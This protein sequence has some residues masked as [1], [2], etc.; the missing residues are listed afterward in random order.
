[1]RQWLWIGLLTICACILS[2]LFIAPFGN[3]IY[4]I[5]KELSD[6]P[7]PEREHE[8]FLTASDNRF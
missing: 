1:M 7:V 5:Y 4:D 3:F 6:D 2:V 8:A